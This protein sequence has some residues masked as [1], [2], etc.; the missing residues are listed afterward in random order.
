MSVGLEGPWL[1]TKHFWRLQPC[2]G[3]GGCGS[4]AKHFA[5]CGRAVHGPET[6]K[7]AKGWAPE[8]SSLPRLQKDCLVLF[9]EGGGGVSSENLWGVLLGGGL[10]SI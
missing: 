3:V 10:C 4:R 2:S 5:V 6:K 8:V 1:K 7:Q 9:L